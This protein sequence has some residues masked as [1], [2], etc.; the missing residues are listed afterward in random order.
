[1]DLRMAVM[2]LEKLIT[3][4]KAMDGINWIKG[5]LDD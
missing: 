5:S 3:K 4:R 2:M 1:M